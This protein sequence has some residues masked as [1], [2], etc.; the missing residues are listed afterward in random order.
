[1]C[2]KWSPVGWSWTCGFLSFYCF[3]KNIK[4]LFKI[5]CIW[6][7][8]LSLI[9]WLNLYL[10][11]KPDLC[12]VT[13][14]FGEDM[15]VWISGNDRFSL[16]ILRTLFSWSLLKNLHILARLS[17][18]DCICSWLASTSAFSHLNRQ[19]M[20]SLFVCKEVQPLIFLYTVAFNNTFICLTAWHCYAVIFFL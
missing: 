8:C 15:L 14:A 1:M 13:C 7:K 16:Q 11:N 12:T 2:G 17:E 18:S 4:Q 3:H 5:L 19:H 9:W 20:W 6:G 10:Y